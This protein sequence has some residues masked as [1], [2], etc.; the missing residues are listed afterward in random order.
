MPYKRGFTN[1][2]KTPWEIVNLD[3][4]AE[5][6]VN[7]AVTPEVLVEA[8]LVR[9]VN[10]PVKILGHGELSKSVTV[11]AH[12]FSKS[13]QAAIE[14]AVARSRPWSAQTSG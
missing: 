1:R 7:G 14:G 9:S 10:L 3:K 11:K 6:E 2:L 4:L 13:A 8:G 5:L 12:A